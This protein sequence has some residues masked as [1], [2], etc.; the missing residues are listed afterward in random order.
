MLTLQ[1]ANE[2]TLPF[3]PS[4]PNQHQNPTSGTATSPTSI[5]SLS[6]D[7]GT[8]PIS[9]S[10]TS[11]TLSAGEGTDHSDTTTSSTP[12]AQ[13]TETASEPRKRKAVSTLPNTNEPPA[14]RT[15]PSIH[16][17]EGHVF[18]SD[19]TKEQVEANPDLP[20]YIF[21]VSGDGDIEENKRLMAAMKFQPP[22]L[23]LTPAQGRQFPLL[24]RM[25]Y[26]NMSWAAYYEADGACQY[27]YK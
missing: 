27:M 13:G 11:V 16:V 25:V 18:R 21:N 20:W 10:D 3:L 24:Q 5:T 23:G 19:Y 17:P 9:K 1:D 6:Q 14:T 2:S 12:V 15:T 26:L 7:T 22:G 8:P 4:L